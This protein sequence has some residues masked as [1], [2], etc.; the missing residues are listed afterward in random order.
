MVLVI[1]WLHNCQEVGTPGG[2]VDWG[3][4][5]MIDLFE[6]K[7]AR[8]SRRS[9]RMFVKRLAFLSYQRLCKQ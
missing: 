5:L 2:V 1:R 7:K 3:I 8:R 4:A 9:P 6:D